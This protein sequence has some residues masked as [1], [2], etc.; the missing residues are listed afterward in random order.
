MEL[1]FTEKQ[2]PALGLTCKVRRTLL[3]EQT[4]YQHLAILETEQFGRMLVLDGMVQTT[5]KDE[6]VYHE[7]I[8]HVALNTHPNPRRVA[9]IGGG[10]GGTVREVLKHRSVEQ[11]V[12]IEIDRRVV[13]ACR[14]YLPSI[15]CALSDPRVEV[16]V[17]DGVEHIR[18][19]ENEYDVVLIDSTEPVGCAVGLFSAPFYRDVARALRE[20]GIMVAQ[21]ESPFVNQ[22]VIR[23]SNAGIRASFPITR[24]YLASIPT[25][26]S[27][28]W[29][30]TLGSKRYDPL[31]VDPAS[32]PPLE[33]RYYT[34]HIHH[35]AFRLPRFVEELVE[36]AAT[37]E[38]GI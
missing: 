28:L 17:A 33:T 18:S 20:D 35:A 16:R 29:S 6:F 19:A 5:E 22:D 31:E 4:P 12:L 13:E 34:P 10:D 30:F 9:V 11:V 26:P 7:M 24:L 25:Y 38:G 2:T 37:V 14:E 23:R 27:G 36:A 1:W 3:E 21:T 15:S 32:I 8:A